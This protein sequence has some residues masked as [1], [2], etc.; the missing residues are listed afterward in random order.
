MRRAEY[1][2]AE[3]LSLRRWNSGNSASPAGV[4]RTA[5]PRSN[6]VTPSC[7]SRRL[8]AADKVGCATPRVLA[9]RVKLPCSQIAIQYITDFSFMGYSPDKSELKPP[10]RYSA[11]KWTTRQPF[12]KIPYWH[13]GNLSNSAWRESFMTISRSRLWL[14]NIR[15]RLQS[16][17]HGRGRDFTAIVGTKCRT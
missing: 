5:P 3:A 15:G 17:S 6:S 16:I 10:L 14:T 12:K 8:I 7:A 9:A 1:S 2:I 11:R 4:N 13:A